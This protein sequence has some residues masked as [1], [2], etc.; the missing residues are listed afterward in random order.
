MCLCVGLEWSGRVTSFLLTIDTLGGVRCVEGDS[1]CV[2]A[3]DA[4]S[5]AH[6][7][8]NI[9]TL[10]LEDYLVVDADTQ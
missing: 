3:C 2:S 7:L 6:V 1:D 9:V 4:G 5:L 10:S 8:L